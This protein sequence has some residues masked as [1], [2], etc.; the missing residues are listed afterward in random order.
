[1]ILASSSPRRRD[2]LSSLGLEF[3]I[4]PAEIKEIPTPHEAAGA[5]A[6]RVAEKKALA[7]GKQYPHAWVVGADTVVVIEGEILGK[8]RDKA[9]AKRMLHQLADKE[10]MVITGYALVKA[11]EETRLGGG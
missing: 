5:F 8:P 11:A 9:D 3:A 6:V 7:A 10:H 4:V 1:M 2:L